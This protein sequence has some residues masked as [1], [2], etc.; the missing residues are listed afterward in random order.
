MPMRRGAASRRDG[1]PIEI[2]AA[3]VALGDVVLLLS[4]DIVPADLRL[5]GSGLLLDRSVLTGESLPELASIRPDPSDAVLAER[6]A[7]AFSGTCVV[8]GFGGGSRSRRL[9]RTRKSA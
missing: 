4:G 5:P 7:M 9:V 6:R 8:G 2:P 1:K 3:D